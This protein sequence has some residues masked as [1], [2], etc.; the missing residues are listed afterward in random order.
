MATTVHG[1]ANLT[2]PDEI[3]GGWHDL[4]P[5][6]NLR[7]V[8]DSSPAS[9]TGIWVGLAAIT[10]TFVAFTSAMIVR[11]GASTDWQHFTLPSVLY[12][13]TLVLL[14][15]SVTLELARKRAAAFV[16][17]VRFERSPSLHWLWMTM[18]LGLLFVAGQCVA[19]RQLR[20]GGLY[21]AT[22]PSSSFFYLFTVLHALHVMGGL[23]GLAMVLW[24][25][26][27]PVPTLRV[28][29]LS[30][31]SYYWHYMSALWIYLLLLLWARI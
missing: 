13:N 17:G 15:S 3:G 18:G 22:N 6:G 11:E 7:S 20:A 31:V 14:A 30:A 23:A 10:M 8:Y 1:P 24:R 27:K 26:S 2:S 29:T 25:I 19:W 12:F 5:S 16:H 28:S 9:R 21:L 4:P